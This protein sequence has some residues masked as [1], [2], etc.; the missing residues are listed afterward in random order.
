M[1]F[2]T[3]G[4]KHF[5]PSGEVQYLSNP[6]LPFVVPNIKGNRFI[7][8]QFVNEKTRAQPDFADLLRWQFG[9]KPQAQQK[10]RDNY[11]PKIYR[12]LS[13]L[14]RSDDDV[15]VWMGHASFFIRMNG[16]CLLT[17]PCY[18]NLGI[19]RRKVGIPFLPSDIPHLDYVLLSHAHRD[20][21][22][23][24]SLKQI[25]RYH[26]NVR[27]LAPLKTGKLI[28][29]SG[30]SDIVEAAWYQRFDTG[31]AD[32]KITFLPA[33]HWHRR[34]VTDYNSMLWGSFL[35]QTS[36]KNLYFAGDTAVGGHFNK[37]A[38]LAGGKVG[39]A[40]MPIGAYK[41]DFIMR[42][43]HINPAEAVEAANVLNADLF[44]PMHYGTYDLSDE[45]PS[46]PPA[47]LQN[48]HQS[49]KL[50]GN[51]NIPAVGEAISF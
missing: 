2:K 42:A 35:L 3:L 15:L 39:I 18:G 38:E 51:C 22:D 24:P 49:G 23:K 26:P 11:R 48:L 9:K 30:G 41:P 32:L 4:K 12:D 10:K 50:H 19:I 45:P 28:A 16:V 8:G 36:D 29:A 6:D 7:D 21:L 34:G 44:V 27:F 1:A 13:P 25:V 14:N 5:T 20:H 47:L 37:I 46:E 17:D 43:S 33:V 31:N 40:L